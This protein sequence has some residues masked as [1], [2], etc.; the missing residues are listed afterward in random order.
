M[1]FRCGI[2]KLDNKEEVELIKI[3]KV[4]LL[5]KLDLSIKFPW[6]VMH[7][8]KELLGLGFMK[9]KTIIAIQVLRLYLSNK[10]IKFTVSKMISA[11]EE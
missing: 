10:R 1:Y 5:R 4:L 7:T 9:P 6:A 8:S 3:Y 2:I 11:V